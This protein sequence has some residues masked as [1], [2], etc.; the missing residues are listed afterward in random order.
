MLE[1][2]ESGK[3]DCLNEYVANG[4]SEKAEKS[5]VCRGRKFAPLFVNDIM[6]EMPLLATKS[7]NTG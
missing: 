7:W 1:F 3:L 2:W 4:K 5:W 6:F